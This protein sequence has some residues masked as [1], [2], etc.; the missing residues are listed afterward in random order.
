MRHVST[1]AVRRTVLGGLAAI[2]LVVALVATRGGDD[3]HVV[4]VTIPKA[5]GVLKGQDV[6][7]AGSKVGEVADIAPVDQGR[8]A[9]LTLR[10]DDRVWPL[11]QGS[12]FA[13][14]WGGTINLF[15]RY[16]ELTRP[17]TGGSIVADGGELPRSAMRVP[18][19][20]GELLNVFDTQLRG[21]LKQMLDRSGAALGRAG[22]PLNRALGR[23]PSAVAAADDVLSDLD[24][25]SQDLKALVRSGGDV[26]S[27][28]DRANPGLGAL[29]TS[30]GTT[31][32]GVAREASGLQATL[33]RAPATF[34]KARGTLE[35][36]DGTLR[37]AQQLTAR[38]SPGVAELRR[39]ASPL[40]GVL[41]TLEDVGPDARRT[42]AVAGAA[43]PDL[44][45][46]LDRVSRIAPQLTSIGTQADTALSCIRPYTPEIV[47][48]GSLWASALSNVDAMGKYIRAT[49]TVSLPALHN[50]QL[51]SSG[52]VARALPHLSYQ[53][54]RPPGSQAGQPWYLPEC[55]AGRDAM[56]PFKD[57]E[58][59]PFDQT[60]NLPGTPEER[61]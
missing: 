53:F 23:A 24:D 3:G 30:A 36:A 40:N 27:A 39:I 46:L 9:R 1:R 7:A 14:R 15:N 45:A 4:H 31:L 49:P 11:T 58:S 60:M 61:P 48:L 8:A 44:T 34:Q 42:L 55:G 13:L 59:R 37:S 22:A 28:I 17:A 32:D 47:S 6:R 51:G 35:R 50:V 29:V 12:R 2:V 41:R 57:P 16:I 19:E 18:V 26:V 21:D 52:D 25:S 10:L 5:T 20:F 38:L 33:D 54:P 56:D 43:A